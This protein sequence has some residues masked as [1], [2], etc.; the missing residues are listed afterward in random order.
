LARYFTAGV[1]RIKQERERESYT[2]GLG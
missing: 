1:R 2:G